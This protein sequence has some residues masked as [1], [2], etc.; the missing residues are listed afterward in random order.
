METILKFDEKIP[1]R[2]ASLRGKTVLIFSYT[3]PLGLSHFFGVFYGF[4]RVFY[5]FYGYFRGF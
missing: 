3:N 2:S 1:S 5:G 4:F